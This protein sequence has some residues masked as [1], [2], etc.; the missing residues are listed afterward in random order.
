MEDHIIRK[1]TAFE[2]IAMY[3]YEQSKKL[4]LELKPLEAHYGI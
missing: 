2:Y 1:L 3:Y 4:G